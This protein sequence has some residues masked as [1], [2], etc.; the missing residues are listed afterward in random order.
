MVVN[1]RLFFD[2]KIRCIRAERTIF[3]QAGENAR[4][5]IDPVCAQRFAHQPSLAG[6][7]CRPPLKTRTENSE[8]RRILVADDGRPDPSLA[9]RTEPVVGRCHAKGL[10]RVTTRPE[11]GSGHWK[12]EHESAAVAEFAL[13]VNRAAVGAHDVL[14]D[15]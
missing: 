5:N 8:P 11:G 6:R 9:P 1:F 14:G 10:L 3:G 12:G 2:A 7:H 4:G 15:G 13:G